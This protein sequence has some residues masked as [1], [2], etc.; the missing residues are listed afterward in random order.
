[1]EP[2]R[3]NYVLTHP[4]MNACPIKSVAFNRSFRYN[5]PV[6]N[7]SIQNKNM[8]RSSTKYIPLQ[9]SWICPCV[10]DLNRFT[11]FLRKLV[12]PVR[13]KQILLCSAIFLRWL[14]ESLLWFIIEV[15]YH[16]QPVCRQYSSPMN[17]QCLHTGGSNY[18]EH[19]YF[20]MYKYS[21]I[22]ENWQFRVDL[23]LRVF[24]IVTSIWH[25]TRFFS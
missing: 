16:G 6:R 3:H 15:L 22:F 20:H 4:Q 5:Y 7:I 25:Y 13:Y 9:H 23:Y 19:G 17:T 8:L 1:M 10:L 2:F 12:I 11:S 14:M 24:N 18:C 21:H